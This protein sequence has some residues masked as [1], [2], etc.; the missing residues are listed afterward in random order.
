MENGSR[1][2]RRT[3]TEHPLG[4][5]PFSA[6]LGC[7]CMSIAA[8]ILFQTSHCFFRDGQASTALLMLPTDEIKSIPLS[9]SSPPHTTSFLFTIFFFFTTV[10]KVRAR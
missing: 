9:N 6:T 2:V 10:S 1:R 3:A 4:S 8:A 5:V 7:V